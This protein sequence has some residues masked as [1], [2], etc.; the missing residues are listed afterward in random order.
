MRVESVESK[1]LQPRPPVASA[2]PISAG[3]TRP[4]MW[5]RPSIRPHLLPGTNRG[6]AASDP[7]VR[8]FWTAVLGPG[9]VADLLRMI[10]SAERGKSLPRPQHLTDLLTIGLAG[11]AMGHVWV[12]ASI[13]DLP[14][15]L[16]QTLP[17]GL[18][19]DHQDWLANER[20]ANTHRP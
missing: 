7:Y 14:P 3:S 15:R 11:R 13:P 12:T 6:R 19:T 5:R 16:V 10:R 18:R 8:R 4:T 1:Q 20:N 9:A 17:A 2:T